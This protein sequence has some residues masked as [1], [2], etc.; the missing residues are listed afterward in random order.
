MYKQIVFAK[1][2]HYSTPAPA[3]TLPLPQ[4]H[5]CPFSHLVN[6]KSL[7]NHMHDLLLKRNYTHRILSFVGHLNAYN[8]NRP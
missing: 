2:V 7:L 3:P 8:S 6:L 4:F 1:F 5:S